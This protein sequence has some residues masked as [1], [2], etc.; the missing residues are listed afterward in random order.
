VTVH[1]PAQGV[2]R[3]KEVSALVESVN[4]VGVVAERPIYFRY[5]GGM[6]AVTGG[7][8]VMGATAPRRSW[9]FAEGYTGAG[10]DE[11]LAILNPNGAPAPVTIT[12][13]LGGGQPPVG[14]QLTVPASSRATVAVHDPA[15]G[16]GRGREVSARVETTLA[17]G[18]VVERPVY[19]R[20]QGSM[21]AV[22]GGHVVGGA[23]A[24][25]PAW[26]FPDGHTAAGWDTYLTLLNPF[27]RDS[28]VRLTYY[29]GGE[30]TPRTKAVVA[31]RNSRT[32]VVV[33][34][35]AQGVGRGKTLGVTVETV[36]GVDLVVERP[37]YF[38]Y[39]GSVAAGGGHDAMGAA[40]PARTWL[41]AEGYTGAGFDEELVVLNPNATAADVT[42]TYYLNGGGPIT[43]TLSV[44][45]RSRS[46]V[47][48]HAAGQVGR[49]KEVSAR[50][51]TSNPGGIVVE[52]PIYFTY[53]GGID[54]GHTVLGHASG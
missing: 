19:F 42:I 5:T 12:Y 3:G 46:S 48:V 39:V 14:K 18:I 30:A 22:T 23:A 33:H 2:G 41:F 53:G 6:G 38:R 34:E 45:P 21:G 1:D 40:A 15:Q 9:L 28:A 50:V 31:P 52:R 47:A 10:F 16:V 25:R 27:T 49:G 32:T 51:E 54:G 43:R 29:V 7:H 35:A 44:A 26:H 24:P 36:N 11:Y 20:Y 8:V 13:Y 37:T 17:A 4:G